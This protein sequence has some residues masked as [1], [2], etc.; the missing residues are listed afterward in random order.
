MKT[1]LTFLLVELFG[2]VVDPDLRVILVISEI[3]EDVFDLDN[4]LPSIFFSQV[5]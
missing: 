4:L 1:A 2:S 5:V 3:L